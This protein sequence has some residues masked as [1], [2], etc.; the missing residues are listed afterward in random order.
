MAE[1]SE[2]ILSDLTGQNIDTS[3]LGIEVRRA[4][5]VFNRRQL[6]DVFGAV[7][8]EAQKQA[9]LQVAT[10]HAGDDYDVEDNVVVHAR[11]H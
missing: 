9:V 7:R 1:V 6:L 11:T 10:H 3:H 4:K 8:S 2:I 5:G